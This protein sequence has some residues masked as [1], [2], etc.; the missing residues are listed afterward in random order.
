MGLGKT[1][2][3]KEIRPKMT[4][5]RVGERGIGFHRLALDE[6]VAQYMESHT[7]NGADP[8][9]ISKVSNGTQ[10]PE[11]GESERL[12]EEKGFRNALRSVAAQKQRPS[13]IRS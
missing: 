8:C 12:S 11:R 13:T 6:A 10:Q 1:V 2:F 5:I 3:E 7:M 4:A 9:Q